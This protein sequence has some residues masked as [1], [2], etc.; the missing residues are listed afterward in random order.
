MAL[1]SFLLERLGLSVY[2]PPKGPL[3][4]VI[5]SYGGALILLLVPLFIFLWDSATGHVD[6]EGG[7]FAAFAFYFACL[8]PI[9]TGL[10]V[11]SFHPQKKAIQAHG[12]SSTLNTKTLIL[13]SI[14][15]PLLGISW[16]KQ[17]PVS[18]GTWQLPLPQA[19]LRWYLSTGWS[20]V[21]SFVFAIV[22]GYLYWLQKQAEKSGDTEDDSGESD[23]QRP[24]LA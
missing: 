24:L 11:I 18:D 7:V 17:F 9:S 4:V 16:L 12:P 13:Q 19:L 2:Y 14:L 5:S 1:K 6:Y 3:K 10:I 23:E 20:A 21:D 8:V 15:F 22:Q